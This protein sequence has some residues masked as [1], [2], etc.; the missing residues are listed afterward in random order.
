MQFHGTCKCMI[1]NMHLCKTNKG[2]HAIKELFC[3]VILWMLFNNPYDI[4][5][6]TLNVGIIYE[7]INLPRN[8]KA[9]AGRFIIT[10]STCSWALGLS[11]LR[12]LILL[13]AFPFL[14]LPT[15]VVTPLASWSAKF[16]ILMHEK[17]LWTINRI[18]KHK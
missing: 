18:A 15:A 9:E 8:C 12:P 7:I 6:S 4:I 17:K 14:W 1:A 13:L 16:R 10:W 5:H 2:D 11:V 3:T